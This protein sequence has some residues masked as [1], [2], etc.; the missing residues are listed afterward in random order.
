MS[1]YGA[2]FGSLCSDYDMTAVAA[3][4]DLNLTLFKYLSRFDILKESAVS[5]LVVLFYGGNRSEFCG[6]FRE[7][8]FLSGF[9]KA[10]VH[11]GPFIILTVCGSGEV[12]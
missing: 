4:P 3:F 5:F 10:L 7:A 12:S 8:L 6:E 11:I 1:A 9:C 2:G